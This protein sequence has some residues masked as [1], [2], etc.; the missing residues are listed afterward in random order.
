MTLAKGREFLMIPGPTNVPDEVL[1][2]MHRP[3][4]DIYDGALL[5]VTDTCM[6]DLKTVFGTAGMPFIYAANGHGAWEA[7]LSNTLS[8]GDKVLVLDSGRF[9]RGWGEMA[10]KLGLEVEVLAGDWRR[11]VDPQAV[12]A[13]LATDTGGEIK[14]VLVVQVDTA[15][16][17][18]NDIPALRR[19]IDAA[20]HGALFMVDT[21][22]SL[23]CVPYEMDAW[24]VDLTVTGAQ[25]G[26]MT[27]PGLAFVAAG[28]KAMAAHESADLVTFYWDWTFRQ[29]SE[30]YQKYCGTPPEHLLYAFRQA[31]DILLGEGLEAAHLRHALLA[32]AVRACLTA[33]AEGGAMEFNILDPRERSDS[34]TVMRTPGFDP[35]ALKTFCQETCGVTIGGTIG[36]I[37]GQGF[38][39]GHMGHVNAPMVLGTLGAME[40]GLAALKIPH[41]R[42]GLQAAIDHL[43]AALG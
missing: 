18:I 10:T 8:R 22:A 32:G 43:A 7:A 38:R 31:L 39:I 5:V 42:G 33:W 23:G 36:E 35:K 28:A 25:K 16:G 14:A 15:S 4:I 29:G 37:A 40:L 2:A 21:I 9:A 13:R 41:G 30:H 20:G 24:G 3:A 27:P 6:A 17:V 12:T 34:V 1:R 26:L 11:A 19:A